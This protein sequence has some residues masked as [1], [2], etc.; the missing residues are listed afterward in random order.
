MS[1]DVKKLQMGEYFY[2][3]LLARQIQKNS[4][5]P[6]D[7]FI[8]TITAWCPGPCRADGDTELTTFPPTPSCAESLPEGHG[9]VFFEAEETKRDLGDFGFADALLRGFASF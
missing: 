8:E 9:V 5:A 6:L 3:S 2:S 1:Y 4:E 7:I